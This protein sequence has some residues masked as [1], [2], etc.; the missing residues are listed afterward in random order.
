[1]GGGWG[2][3]GY[4]NI[5]AERRCGWPFK[6]AHQYSNLTSSVIGIKLSALYGDLQPIRIFT[7]TQTGGFPIS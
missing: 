6:R 7:L 1:M 5:F 3:G 4:F 2:D